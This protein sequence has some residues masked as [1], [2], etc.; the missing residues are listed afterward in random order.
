M[1]LYENSA[2]AD[3]KFYKLSI[4]LLFMFLKSFLFYFIIK[5]FELNHIKSHKCCISVIY[6]EIQITL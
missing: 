5:S 1:N 6:T 2:A 4:S 3:A